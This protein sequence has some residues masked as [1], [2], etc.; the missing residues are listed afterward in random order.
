MNKWIRFGG[1]YPTKLLRA[2]R[3]GKTVCEQ[4]WM[5]EHMKLVE[6]KSAQFQHD[7]V[8][9]NAKNLHWWIEKHNDYATKEAIEH[10]NTKHNLLSSSE[11]VQGS[12]FVHKSDVK[13]G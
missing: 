8:D 6:G 7:M 9:E 11:Y 5:D 2:W 12:L 1:Y 4:R 3:V 13:D 10:L